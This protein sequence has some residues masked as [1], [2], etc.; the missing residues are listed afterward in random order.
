LIV[1]YLAAMDRNLVIGDERGIPWHLPADLKRFRRLTLGKPIVMGRT[2]FEHI[3]K[4]LDK[5]VNIVLS[6][7]TDFRPDGVLVARSVEDAVR[8]AGGVPE[9]MVVGGGRVFEAALPLVSRMYL[10]FV[11]GEFPGTAYFPESVSIS[12]GT[13]WVEA[14]R[15]THRADEKNPYPHQYVVVE[16]VLLPGSPGGALSIRS[17]MGPP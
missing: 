9:L 11:D 17:L 10:T 16:R 7:R 12:P 2:T 4:P 3:G 5:R 8:L 15:E 13:G 6:R 14:L 1:T